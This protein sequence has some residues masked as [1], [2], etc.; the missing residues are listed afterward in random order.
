MRSTASDSYVPA[1]LSVLRVTQ[2]TTEGHIHSNFARHRF[3][4]AFGFVG[5]AVQLNPEFGSL[6]PPS[7]CC[8]PLLAVPVLIRR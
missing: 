1:A 2:C 6:P 7:E 3:G 4:A 8:F 5:R